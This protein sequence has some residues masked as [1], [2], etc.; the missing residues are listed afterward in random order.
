MSIQHG[1]VQQ[2]SNEFLGGLT[3]EEVIEIV[4]IQKQL[5]P[6]DHD[7]KLFNAIVKKKHQGKDI[8]MYME[9]LDL[10]SHAKNPVVSLQRKLLL[11]FEKT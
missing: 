2:N 10:N 8:E 9:N 1:T 3:D 11:L 6:E 7:H 4:S 5:L